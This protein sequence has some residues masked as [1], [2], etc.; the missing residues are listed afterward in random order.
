MT[1]TRPHWLH[2]ARRITARFAIPALVSLLFVARCQGGL[3]Q[4]ELECEQ[5]ANQLA[6]CCPNFDL[7]GL[8]CTYS[9]ACDTVYP[10]LSVSQSQCILNESCATLVASGVCARAAQALPA[11]S[12]QPPSSQQGGQGGSQEGETPDTPSVCP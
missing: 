10:A 8:S 9:D 12:A 11:L 7:E 6:N 5:A 1:T 2:I 3:R 4:D